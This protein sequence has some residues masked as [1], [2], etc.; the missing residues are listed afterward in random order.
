MLSL[1]AAAA[2]DGSGGGDDDD[3][4]VR[5]SISS[6]GREILQKA[7]NSFDCLCSENSKLRWLVIHGE[8]KRRSKNR[9]LVGL[10]F[11]RKNPVSSFLTY[12]Q[13]TKQ[14]ALLF[15]AS[16]TPRS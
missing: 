15:T 3:A 2:A 12:R 13:H 11:P 9:K 1:L 4:D 14:W 10:P 8:R 5:E 7:E 16:I 6:N